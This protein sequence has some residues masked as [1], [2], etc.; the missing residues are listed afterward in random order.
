LPAL[1][2]LQFL[3]DPSN[4][5]QVGTWSTTFYK[6]TPTAANKYAWINNDACATAYQ[7][8]CE[9]P[10]TYFNCPTSPP[11]TPP[12]SPYSN[13]LCACT[14]RR[15]PPCYI[16]VLIAVL[17]TWFIA[18][19]H[20]RPCAVFFWPLAWSRVAAEARCQ[21]LAILLPI[22][23]RPQP[24]T[25]PPTS[26]VGLPANDRLTFC[27][28]T[29]GSCYF[30]NATSATYAVHKARCQSMGGYLVSYNTAAEQRMVETALSTASNVYM[31]I[32]ALGNSTLNGGTFVMLDGTFLGNLTPSSSN[33]YKHW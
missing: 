20:S 14:G 21:P 24:L 2:V 8:M 1:P 30:Y 22:L 5:T 11:P 6:N 7:S 29:L 4:S 9:I 27:S 32:E 28:T 33:P 26:A 31:G 17:L 19:A 15:M 3:G 12:P 25:A 13:G 10:K 16:A 23:L 18:V